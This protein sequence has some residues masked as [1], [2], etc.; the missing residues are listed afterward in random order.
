MAA[1]RIGELSESL[2]DYIEIGAELVRDKP[3]ARVR[4]IAAHKS[5]SMASVTG[6]LK[7]LAK[8]GLVN[9]Q[10]REFV[11]LTPAGSALGEKLL[12]RHDLLRRFLRDVLFV[13]A[14]TAETDACGLEH[15]LSRVTV[16]RLAELF[17]YLGA[18][19]G[20]ASGVLKA[21]RRKIKP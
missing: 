19:K 15:H 17:H 6:A 7:R 1:P 12:Y 16:E 2:E 9:Y 11:E 10:A 20:A 14:K 21:F 5:V 18:G 4:D 3:V 13:D 8:E